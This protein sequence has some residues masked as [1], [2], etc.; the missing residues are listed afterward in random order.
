MAT[1]LVLVHGASMDAASN[2]GHLVHQLTDV[3]AVISPDYAGSGETPLP[4][5]PLELE[6]L[7]DQV[8][9]AARS[10][11]AGPVDLVGFSL[12]AVV[13]AELAAR[14]P[15]LVRRLVLVAGWAHS[16]DARLR[17]ALAT[18]S[19]VIDAAPELAS[20]QGPLMAFS[21]PFLSSL[22]PDGL[23]RL[24]TAKPAPGT[25]QQIELALRVD[26]RDRL[27]LIKAPTLVVGCTLD[28][29]VPVEHSRALHAAIPGSRYVE[30]ES[31]HVVFL[32]RPEEI[33]ALLREFLLDE[34]NA[35]L[36]RHFYEHIYAGDINAAVDMLHDDFT[37]L[38]ATENAA[39]TAAVPW[40]GRTLRGR[41]GFLELATMLFGEFES[42]EFQAKEFHAIGDQVFVFGHFSFRHQASGRLAVSD[43]A[44]RFAVADGKI[45]GGQFFEDTYSVAVA[46]A[47][48][49]R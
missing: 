25:R 45:L 41:E 1:G 21:P 20:A 26:L 7:V 8:V 17:L 29:L 19:D 32:E 2:F 12:G 33:V 46:R 24:R 49:T 48:A 47:E 5:G 10:G 16:D 38:V 6:L 9:A 37:W 11:G 13:A 18:W 31:G 42:L 3:R 30:L 23:A 14:Y 40:A 36:V 27:P 39:L 28:Y 15:E 34:N 44:A 35:D 43:W 22:G 4:V